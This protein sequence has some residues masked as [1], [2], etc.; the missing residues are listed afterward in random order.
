[1]ENEK[2]GTI[3][4]YT[5]CMVLQIFSSSCLSLGPYGRISLVYGSFTEIFVDRHLLPIKYF[6]DDEVRRICKIPGD[7]CGCTRQHSQRNGLPLAYP[8]ITHWSVFSS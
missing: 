2:L 1:M 7:P 3:E 8:W 4:N 6:D 5:N